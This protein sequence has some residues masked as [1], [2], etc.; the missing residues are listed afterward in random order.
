[1]GLEEQSVGIK[2]EDFVTFEFEGVK[3]GILI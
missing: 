3:F 1:L 2:C